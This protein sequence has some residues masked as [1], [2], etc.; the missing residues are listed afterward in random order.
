MELKAKIESLVQLGQ[1]LQNSLALY[2]KQS[3]IYP[4]L[5]LVTLQEK[6]ASAID[7]VQHENGWFTPESVVSALSAWVHTLEKETIR[8]W[9]STY[10]FTVSKI[11]AVG[12]IMAGNIPLVGLHDALCVLISGNKL[13]A[14]LSSKDTRLMSILLEALG[15]LNKEWQE[16]IVIAQ[17]LKEI[18]VLIATGSDNS[19][20]YFEYYFKDKKRLI[21]KNRTSVAL[22]NGEETEVELE[23]LANDIFTHYGLG[24]RNVT[25]LYLPE[26]FDLDRVFNAL[27]SH[28]EIANHNKYANNYDYNK[29]VYLL[30]KIDL[31]EN[32]FLLLKEDEG[33]HSPVG[34]LFYEYYSSLEEVKEV[35]NQKTDELQCVVTK[36]NIEG[37]TSFGKAQSPELKDYADGVDTLDFLLTK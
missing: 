19:S 26:G 23:G 25:K 34:V 27:Y 33:L 37:A 24:C 9:L 32:G 5:P 1:F 36:V 13:Y 18:D 28:K 10:E 11:E 30:N 20:R 7:I 22:L 29:A 16:Q 15:A 8:E 21:R 31:L 12:V 3:I 4:D 2:N 17:Q 6:L 35:L 14:K